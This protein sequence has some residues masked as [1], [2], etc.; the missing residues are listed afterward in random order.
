MPSPPTGNPVGHPGFN[1]DWNKIDFLLEA[2]CIGTQIAA[3]L[4]ISPDTLYNHCMKEKG[5]N[6]SAYLK[7]KRAK[8]DSFLHVKQYEMAQDG[9]VTMLLWLGKNRL[10]QKENPEPPSSPN[11][12]SLNEII[13]SLNAMNLDKVKELLNEESNT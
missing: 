10:N 1:I 11:D 7:E 2:G 8:G 6:F 13:G 5:V 9:N 3:S 4:G 12:N